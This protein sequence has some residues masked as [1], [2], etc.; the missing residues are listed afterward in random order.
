MCVCVCTVRCMVSQVWCVVR[1]AWRAR[2]VAYDEVG[3]EYGEQF[4][5]RYN[6]FEGEGS[7][8]ASGALA[9]A[10][11]LWVVAARG[12]S[13][14]RWRRVA[15][16][17]CS[18]PARSLPRMRGAHVVVAAPPC[19]RTTSTSNRRGRSPCP[20]AMPQANLQQ[21]NHQSNL[22]HMFEGIGPATKC[23]AP[24]RS[25]HAGSSARRPGSRRWRLAAKVN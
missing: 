2:G 18:P 15:R 22:R 12:I 17:V 6:R 8:G 4:A 14:T 5:D 10:R 7:R 9:L 3:V 13:V 23:L 25:R 1:G 20:Q 11:L 21:P 19:R 16:R 24:R